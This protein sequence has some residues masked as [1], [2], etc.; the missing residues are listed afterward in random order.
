MWR[1]PPAEDRLLIASSRDASA[2]RL[3]LNAPSAFSVLPALTRAR[4]AAA[5]A[6]RVRCCNACSFTYLEY[7]PFFADQHGIAT[8]RWPPATRQSSGSTANSLQGENT[9]KARATWFFAW[10]F[11]GFTD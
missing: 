10:Q 1:F 9:K 3:L 2:L 6:A 8:A 11:D 7:F 4:A 5:L